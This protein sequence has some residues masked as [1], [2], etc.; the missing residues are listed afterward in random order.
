MTGTLSDIDRKLIQD[1]TRAL[2]RYVDFQ[3]QQK[4]KETWIKVGEVRRLTGWD[5]RKMEKAR[6]C[7]MV[8]FKKDKEGK[9]W[10]LLESIPAEYL[11]KPVTQ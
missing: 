6:E 1:H 2:N 4:R 8:D 3:R 11:L 5:Y 9:M 10:Y 7:R